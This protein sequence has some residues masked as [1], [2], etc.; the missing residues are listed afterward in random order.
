MKLR[1]S[2]LLL[3]SLGLALAQ[4][5]PAPVA[6]NEPKS[7]DL[8]VIKPL[9]VPAR[10]GISGEVSL[11]LSEVIQKVL[12][13]DRDLAVSRIIAQEARQMES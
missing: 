8:P 12:D 9:E 2:V 7:P 13:N 4:N 10:I 1:I 5:P 3:C 6:Q 11:T